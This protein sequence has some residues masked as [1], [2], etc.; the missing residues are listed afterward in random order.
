MSLLYHKKM[1]IRLIEFFGARD[2]GL[3]FVI[4]STMTLPFWI[5][6]I[7]F[8]RSSLV[9]RCA[10]PFLACTVYCGVLFSLLWKAYQASILPAPM[11]YATYD[12]AKGFFE[13]PIA[14]LVLFCNLQILNLFLGTMM[15]RKA[16]KHGFTA[17]IE[18]ALCYVLGVVALVPFTVRLIL[19]GERL[20]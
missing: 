20:S 14:F 9:V 19:R 16:L 4:L 17:P 8:G 18:L 7:F 11:I 10:Q 6:M 5:G 3:S 15:Y 2:L 12:S 13:H 1:P